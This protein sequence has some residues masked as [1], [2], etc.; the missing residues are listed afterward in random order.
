MWFFHGKWG[1]QSY[2]TAMLTFFIISAAV[3][4]ADLIGTSW[5]YRTPQVIANN[6]NFSH[7]GLIAELGSYYLISLGDIKF[8]DIPATEG[9]LLAHK[10][11]VV[12][13]GANLSVDAEI[14]ALT[15]DKLDLDVQVFLETHG[16]QGPYYVAEAPPEYLTTIVKDTDGKE[17]FVRELLLR[18]R[19]QNKEISV[20]RDMLEERFGNVKK[21]VDFAGNTYGAINN[22]KNVVSLIMSRLKR[23]KYV[24]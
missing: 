5:K 16:I 13:I 18:R 17:S 1:I 11:V 19:Q 14:T 2:D 24:E 12:P 4:T 23:D 3:E 6:R 22:E 9:H 10:S 7:K 8:I 15:K 21:F 20:M